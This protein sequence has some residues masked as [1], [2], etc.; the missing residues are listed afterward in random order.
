MPSP[1]GLHPW[2]ISQPELSFCP[3][4]Q[5][6]IHIK[7]IFQRPFSV[8]TCVGL[9]SQNDYCFSPQCSFSVPSLASHLMLFAASTLPVALTR[10]H[11]GQK[12][13]FAALA[14]GVY[15][16]LPGLA[17]SF[18]LLLSLL[19]ILSPLWDFPYP[20]LWQLLYDFFSLLNIRQILYHYIRPLFL[21]LSLALSII[22]LP[23]NPICIWVI[24]IVWIVMYAEETVFRLV[25]SIMYSAI[26][27]LFF[28]SEKGYHLY[29][30]V[31]NSL[32]IHVQCDGQQ[33]ILTF[34]LKQTNNLYV[35]V[36]YS[37][38]KSCSLFW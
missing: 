5:H 34:E 13:L 28:I 22:C 38:K 4:L 31:S 27:H 1:F 21:Y 7:S 11:V 16:F 32:K 12:L 20:P 26:S 19:F 35:W 14:G 15:L 6:E 33:Q 17:V 23:Y 18:S 2:N 25:G 3:N 36:T 30:E 24:R 29:P 10:S 8:W 9:H 37:N